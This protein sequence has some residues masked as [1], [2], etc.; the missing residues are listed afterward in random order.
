MKTYYNESMLR[1]SFAKNPHVPTSTRRHFREP[2]PSLDLFRCGFDRMIGGSVK[3]C[4]NGPTRRQS[5]VASHGARHARGFTLVEVIVAVVI[6]AVALSALAG[7]FGGGARAAATASELTRASALAQGLL[8]SAGVEKP[9]TDGVESGATNDGL[10]WTVTV[11]D[12]STEGDDSGTT[13]S[14][15]RPPLLLK[16]VTARVVVANDT[17]PDRGRVVELSTLRAIPRPLLQ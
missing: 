11:T 16:R 8:A 2:A 14:P 1:R 9:L 15:I 7:V 3:T 4:R 6:A 13:A 10:R 5:V 12:E 17:Q